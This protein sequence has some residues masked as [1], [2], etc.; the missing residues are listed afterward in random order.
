MLRATEPLVAVRLEPI[1]APPVRKR[2]AQGLLNVAAGTLARWIDETANLHRCC[3]IANVED[4]H[5][6][7][8]LY[9]HPLLEIQ[10][11]DDVPWADTN[12]PSR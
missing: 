10:P 7:H 9:L 4:I 8:G 2:L 11:G 5:I 1:A 12:D 6:A 3:L